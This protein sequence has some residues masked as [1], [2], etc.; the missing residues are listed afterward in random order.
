MGGAHRLDSHA[1]DCRV[2]AGVDGVRIIRFRI[3]PSPRLDVE[4]IRVLASLR[5][6]R[7]TPVARIALGCL[8]VFAVAVVVVATGHIVPEEIPASAVVTAAELPL[9]PQPSAFVGPV[10]TVD[11]P[12]LTPTPVVTSRARHVRPRVYPTVT[13]DPPVKKKHDKGDDQ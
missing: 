11:P 13:P 12:V 9:M 5:K 1:Y 2:V 7:V 4:Q 10:A 8:A 3:V 6:P